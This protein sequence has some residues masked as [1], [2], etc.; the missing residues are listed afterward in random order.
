MPTAVSVRNIR[1]AYDKHVAVDD[2]SFQIERGIVYGL[3]G[4]NGAGKTTTIRMI[5]DILKPD[6]G[7]IEVLGTAP[8]AV[9][10]RI[11]YLPEERGLYKKMKVI[12]I[13]VYLGALKGM[14]Q[15][16]A[17][18]EADRWLERV[19]LANWRER[20]IEELS[21]GMAQKVQFVSTLL[22]KPDLLILDEPFSGLDPVNANQLKDVFLEVNRAGTT[23]VFSTHLMESAEKLCRSICLINRGRVVLEG[24]LVDVKRRYGKN[25][26][27]LEF[28]GDGGFIRG[29]PA[30]K[31]IDD[32]GT[33]IE[34]TLAD[35]TDPQGLLKAASER[36][37]IRRF[38]VVEPTLHNVFLSA[39]GEGHD[40]PKPADPL[41]AQPIAPA[42]VEVSR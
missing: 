6:S 15:D 41:A 5:M 14:R 33:Y 31:S 16:D 29:L 27:L 30:V 4:P 20:K 11:G 38:E 37:R 12:D 40:D 22:A 21:K 9:L 3:L 28:D 35:G 32:Y 26:I 2:I 1:K 34:V 23:I 24:P 42:P 17:K 10:D 13:L 19:E 25:N 8:A 18:R 36:L 7:S 39:V